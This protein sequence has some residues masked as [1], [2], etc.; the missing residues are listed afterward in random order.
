MKNKKI[1][2]EKW[3][4]PLHLYYKI[5]SIL[6]KELP[7]FPNLIDMIDLCAVKSN[8]KCEKYF[9][10]KDDSI[11]MNWHEYGEWGWLALPYTGWYRSPFPEHKNKKMPRQGLFIRKA[12]EESKYGFKTISLIQ[13]FPGERWWYWLIEKNPYCDY[14]NIVG[15][16]RYEDGVLPRFSNSL[17]IFGIEKNSLSEDTRRKLETLLQEDHP[18]FDDWK[19]DYDWQLPEWKLPEWK[20]EWKS[21]NKSKKYSFPNGRIWKNNKQQHCI[22]RYTENGIDY[23]LK[24]LS[25]DM[26]FSLLNDWRNGNKNSVHEYFKE[27]GN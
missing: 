12:I 17:V 8:R 11:S 1:V 27:V 20:S 7:N 6:S 9:S 19:L 25:P 5:M 22:F 21:E 24:K 15:R 14:V 4:T 16:M 26:A 3:G 23:T 13:T 18:R 10:P 2:D